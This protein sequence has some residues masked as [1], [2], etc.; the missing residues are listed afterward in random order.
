MALAVG[1]LSAGGCGSTGASPARASLSRYI[2]RA[3]R[4]EQQLKAPLAQV[5]AVASRLSGASA[6]DPSAAAQR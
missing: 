2:V 5:S 3:E 1:A 4:I 6:L